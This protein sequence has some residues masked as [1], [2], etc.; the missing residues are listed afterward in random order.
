MLAQFEDALAAL[1]F[2]EGGLFT[3]LGR[4]SVGSWGQIRQE[5]GQIGFFRNWE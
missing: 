4:R 5:E 1:F 2:G 3:G